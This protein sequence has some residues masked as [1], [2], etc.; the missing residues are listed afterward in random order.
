MTIPTRALPFFLDEME[1]LASAQVRMAQQALHGAEDA[2]KAFKRGTGLSRFNPFS[3]AWDD[4]NKARANV[5]QA[6]SQF[7]ADVGRIEAEARGTAANLG[8]NADAAATV[9]SARQA[10]RQAFWG[11]RTPVPL[12]PTEQ[13]AEA[14]TKKQAADAAAAK[15]EA[16]AKELAAQEA[17]DAARAKFRTRV[18]LG[19]VGVGAGALYLGTRPKETRQM[20]Y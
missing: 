6:R 10:R 8:D 9:G 5:K 1:K 2:Y 17:Q 15:A 4:A 3:S 12:T 11:R 18:G 19:A 20:G 7:K 14:A 13:A 16:K